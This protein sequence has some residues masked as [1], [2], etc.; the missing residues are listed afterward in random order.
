MTSDVLTDE[1]RFREIID[2]AIA[3]GTVDAFDKYTKETKAAKKRRRDNAK[4]EAKEAEEMAKKMGVHDALFGEGK[5]KGKGK[6]K[7]KEEEEDTTAL[8]AIIKSRGAGRME[9]LLAGLE[10]RYGS[11]SSKKTSR[12]RAQPPPPTEEEFEAA[13]AKVT[14]GRKKR[15]T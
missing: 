1:A 6:G 3:E 7:G 2:A 15:K 12:K 10:A 5:K 11:G 14:A 8:A 9:N 4:K 13:R